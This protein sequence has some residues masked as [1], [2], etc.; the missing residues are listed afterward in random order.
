MMK[1]PCFLAAVVCAIVASYAVKVADDKRRGQGGG[2]RPQEGA[3][4]DPRF[5]FKTDVPA[6]PLD[7]VLGRP[8]KDSIT[9]SVLT[10]SDR[11]GEIAYGPKS[12]ASAAKT[13][14]FP[15]KAG[16]PVEIELT[17]LAADTRHFYTLSTREHGRE[18]KQEPERSFHTQRAPGKA[19]TFTVQAD[20]PLDYGIDT[21]TYEKSLANALAAKTDFHVD[22]GDTFMVDKRPTYT[23]AEPNVIT[24]GC[25]DTVCP[26]SSCSE[27]TTESAAR[28]SGAVTRTCEV[29]PR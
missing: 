14:V 27:I 18:W 2:K 8:T 7:V 20:P 28:K 29:R 21:P 11:E 19:F 23:L 17:G 15:L 1:A 26:S 9:V 3:V 10:Y 12:G 16:E 13:G 25:S 4:D 6:H 5:L 22:L 24:L